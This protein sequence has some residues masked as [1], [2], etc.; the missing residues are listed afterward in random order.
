MKRRGSITIESAIVIPVCLFIIAFLMSFGINYAGEIKGKAIRGLNL[1]KVQ[2]ISRHYIY[3]VDQ[4]MIVRV[5]DV[6]DDFLDQ[7][8]Y[9]KE[10]KAEMDEKVNNLKEHFKD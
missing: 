2:L 3:G 4:K 10:I 5:T 8:T 7:F 1:E 9:T 6:V